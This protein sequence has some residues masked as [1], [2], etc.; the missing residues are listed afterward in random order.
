MEHLVTPDTILCAGWLF[1]PPEMSF[2]F[3]IWLVLT[4]SDGRDL[5]FEKLAKFLRR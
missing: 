3:Y 2:L 5:I 1:P 4:F